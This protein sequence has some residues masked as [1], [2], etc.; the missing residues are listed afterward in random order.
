[1]SGR[2]DAAASRCRWRRTRSSTSTSAAAG[3]PS[4]GACSLE[5]DH[6]PEEWLA[7]TV[8]R[9]GEPGVGPARTVDGRAVRRRRGSRPARLGRRPR[10]ATPASWSSCSTPGSG[11]PCTCTPTGASRAAT[12]AAATARPRPGT[13]SPPTRAPPCTSAGPRTSTP[14]SWPSGATAQDSDVDA[15]AAA[16]GARPCGRRDPGAGG[17]AARDRRGGLRG[18]GPGAHRLLDRARVV[19]HDRDARGVPPRPRLRHRHGSGEPPRAGAR[20]ARRAA[21][22]PAGGR[23]VRRADALPARAGRSLLPPRR[24][25][26]ALGAES[27]VEAGYAVAGG[28][29]RSRRARLR[30]RRHGPGPG[31]RLRRAGRPRRLAAARRR[32]RRRRPSGHRARRAWEA[33]R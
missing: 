31:R 1:M 4:C 7:A 3:S 14:T 30:R 33:D 13:S 26:A 21:P 9:A 18:R 6:R 29:G 19:G 2:Y 8:S 27:R 17:P 10:S 23:A 22:A 11:C 20:G 16:P 15:R 24:A 32:A 12:S 25:R 5:S 28:A